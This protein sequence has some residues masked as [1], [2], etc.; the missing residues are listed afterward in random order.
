MEQKSSWSKYGVGKIVAAMLWCIVATCSFLSCSKSDDAFPYNPV[1]AQSRTVMVYMVGENS[2]S[3]AVPSDIREMLNTLAERQT[4]YPADHLVLYVDD[5]GKPRI[6]VIDRN[7]TAT[8]LAD[9]KPQKPYE[10]DGN[11]SSAE[12]LNE[13]FQYVKE[14]YPADSY[15][16]VMWS[17]ASGWIPS[18]YS[19][20]Q[21]AAAPR[22]SFGIDNGRNSSSVNVNVGNQMN[23]K[24]MARVLK[25]QGG[26][27]FI[28]FDACFMQC[29]EVAY[30][31]RNATKHVI[32]SP[33]E[34]PESGA[35]YMTMVPAMFYQDNVSGQ[36]LNAYYEEYV[37]KPYWG[38]VMSDVNTSA[39]PAFAAYMKQLVSQ[40]KDALLTADYTGVLDYYRYGPRDTYEYKTWGTTN[41]DFYDMQGLMKRVLSSDDYAQWLNE[42][43]KVVTCSH[44][45][46]WYSAVLYPYYTGTFPIDAEQCCGMSMFVPLV[47]YSSNADRFCETYLDTSWAED[48]WME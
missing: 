24:D 7:T 15:G 48:V 38:I 19:G 3:S 13:F 25:E 32:A 5:L 27:D 46:A 42:V 4:F 9:L 17:H 41:P 28:L 21:P 43:A 40:Y 44:T 10:V 22:R 37:N 8:S 26:V 39:L 20:D 2:L 33:A 11:S 18:T 47:K 16:L 29:V 36:I 34:I 6:Y 14:Y 23:I 31:L 12:R 30:E 1:Y 45:N 35:N